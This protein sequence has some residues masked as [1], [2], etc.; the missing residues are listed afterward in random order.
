MKKPVVLRIYKND[1]L[2]G[3]KQFLEPQI[4]IGRQ[5]EVQVALDGD[6]VSLIHASIEERGGEYYIC[7][8]GSEAGTVLNGQRVLDT[9]IESGDEIKI[10]EYK[11][12]F[13]LGAPRPKG[14]GEVTNPSIAVAP[15][16]LSSATPPPTPKAPAPPQQTFKAPSPASL[17]PTS[18]N[19]PPPLGVEPV[20][21]SPASM[22]S[23]PV[24]SFPLA[25]PRANKKTGR[26]SGAK[27]HSQEKT[28]APASH[29]TDVKDFVK[30]SKGTVVEIL[31]AWRE[32]VIATYHFSGKSSGSSTIMMGSHPGNDIVLPVFA[33][34]LRKYP[35]LKLD[36]Q[37]VVLVTPEMTGELI[38]GQS[39][40][41]FVDLL[42]Q[43]KMAKS[44]SQYA[45]SLDQG[46][47]VRVELN[48]QV[49][50]IVR[51]VSD[52]PKPVMAPL[53]D[54]TTAEF[55]GVLLSVVLVA[56]LGLYTYL[57]S[58]PKD[59]PDDL[60]N[61]PVRTAMIIM[62]TPTPAP[63]PK[64]PPQKEV[65]QPT[66]QPTPPPQ[67]VKATPSPKVEPPKVK[68]HQA[69]TNLTTKN[70]NGKSANA[71]P[72]KNKTGPR[73]LTT[74]K[75]G[76]AIKTAAKEG[77]QM[78]SK[79][80]DVSK[81]GVF[82]VFGNAGAQDKLAQSTTGS[83]ELAGL[84][85]QATGR[86]GSAENRAGQGLGSSLKDTGVGGNGKALEGIA[87]GVGTTGRGSGNAGY[88]TGGLGNHA[89]TKIV[90]GGTEE[91]FSGSIDREAVRRVVLA[92][93]RVVKT[94]YERQL[95]RSPDLMGK[96]V[97][98]W[99]IG[100]QGR[101]ISAGVQSNELGEK[102]GKEVAD[103]IV[104]NLKTWKF[105]EPPPNQQVTVAFPFFFSN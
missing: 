99:D 63:L 15:P 32:R 30:P 39:S 69:V 20:T 79:S 62:Q 13:F 48:D 70:D 93:M 56:T 78:Q 26:A 88:G 14:V 71:A 101:V 28:F 33:S 47:M 23:S 91:S 68:Q 97:I 49:S 90:T 55:T 38:R 3:V 77:S 87:G 2:Q 103:C 25:G 83:G 72:T 31:V 104:Q 100:E 50:L 57:Y 29:Y 86:A 58:P 37:A 53:L 12:E 1:Q 98:T 10:G 59:L 22:S 65:V 18:V 19:P 11:I 96:V 54:F 21:S 36:R 60:D 52:S 80:R 82:S 75:S 95:N 92:N 76:G 6:L 74:P 94:C 17:A 4:V 66:P 67:I 89:G 41:S 40:S 42:R 44:G 51:Y 43:N 85:S 24:T 105:P 16:T 34:R 64:P 102:G 46:E 27:K 45:I 81:S 35:I 5:G 8:L 61:E 73:Q 7:D 84:A 9:K